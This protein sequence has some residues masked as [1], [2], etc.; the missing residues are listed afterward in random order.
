MN[1]SERN[2]ESEISFKSSRSGGK[3]GQNVNKVSTAVH[4][5]HK[6]TGL[7]FDVRTERYQQQNR[8][9]ALEL[10]KNKLCLESFR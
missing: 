7:M 5:V 10:L 9:I 8:E 2:F 6:P 3:G 4:L 1:L